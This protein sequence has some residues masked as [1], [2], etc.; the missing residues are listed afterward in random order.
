[1]PIHDRPN[2]EPSKQELWNAFRGVLS[3]SRQGSPLRRICR[4]GDLPLSFAQQ[5]FWLIEQLQPDSSAYNECVAFLRLEGPL[6][7]AALEQSLNEIRHRHEVLRTTF[8]SVNGQPIQRISPYAPVALSAIDLR[9]F[10]P[11]QREAI[12]QRHATE[13]AQQ[14]F[15]LEQGPLLRVKLLRLKQEEYIF[16]VTIHHIIYDGWSHSVFIQELSELYKAFSNHNPSPL[17]ELPI[18]YADFAQ[19]QRQWLQGKILQSQI[20]YWMQQLSGNLPVLHLPIDRPQPPIQTYQG[21]THAQ[22]LPPKLIEAL[23]S[24]SESED[25]TLFM[26]LLAAF[27]ALLYRYTGQEDILIGSPIANRNRREISGLIGCFINTLVLRTDL[28]RNPTFQE[29]LERVRAV[30]LAAFAHQDLPFEKLVE[31]LQPE[32]DLSRSPLFQVMFVFQHAPTSSLKLEGLTLSP[33]PV[34]NKTAKFNLT[35][36]LEQSPQ[37]LMALWEYNTD[38]F[39]ASTI[40]RMAGHFQILLEGIVAQPQQRIAEL[41]LL[42]AVEQQQLRVEWNDTPAD[43]PLDQCIHELFEM[44]VQRT[45]DA[46]AVVYGNQQLTYYQLNSRANQLARYLQSV[47]VK[48]DARVG[49]CVERSLEMVVGLLGIL[50]AGGAYVPLDPH[51]PQERLSDMLQ[52]AA[53]SVLLTQQQWVASLPS[54]R[55]DIVCLDSQWQVIRTQSQENPVSQV[56]ATNLAYVIYTSGSTGQPKGIA[57]QHDSLVNLIAWQLE[58]AMSN[59]KAKTLQ[60]A[61]VSFDVSFQEIFSTWCGG[62]VLV[63]ISEEIRRDACAL[64]RLLVEAEI[65]RLFLPVVALQQLA[66]VADRSPCHPKNLREIITAG[67]QLQLTP[68][69]ISFFNKLPN[70]VLHNHYG[71]SETHVVTA[72]T[73]NGSA[74]DWPAIPPIGRPIANT[75]LYILGD[76]LQPVPVGVSGELYISGAGVARGYFNRPDLTQA[77]FIP[78]PFSPQSQARLYKTGDLA[79]YLPDGNAQFLGRSDRQVKIR[80]FRIEPGEVETVLSTHPQVQQAVVVVR[81]DNPANKRLVAYLVSDQESLSSSQLR[82]FLKQKLPE[83]MIPSAF[84]MLAAMPLTPSGKLDRKALPADGEFSRE[85]NFVLPR[86]PTEAAIA[87]IFTTVLGL[88]QISIHNNFF[89]IGGHSLLA[90]QVISRLRETFN[91]ELPLRRLFELTTV[92]QLSQALL[93]SEQNKADVIVQNSQE[94]ENLRFTITPTQ[95]TS[96]QF[97]LSFTQERLWFLDRLEG[98]SN[99]YNISIAFQLQGT[100]NIAVLEQA[101]A[102]IIQRHEILRTRFITTNGTPVQIIDAETNFTLSV[103]DLQE[104]PADQRSDQIQQKVK[105][106]LETSFDLAQ[107]H[108]VRVMLLQVTPE[109]FVLLVSTHHIVFD[110]WSI[111]IF[112]QEL[113]TLYPAFLANSPASLPDLPIQYADFAVWQRQWWRGERLQTQLDY[114]KQQ[115]SHAPPLLEL[116]SDRSRPSVQTFRGNSL[117]FMLNP[118]LSNQ[119]QTLSQNAGTTLFMTLLAAFATLLYR[120]SAQE[121]ILIGSPI[122]NRNHSEIESLIGSFINTLVFRIRIQDNPGF[123]ELLTQVRQVALEAYEHQDAPFEKIVEALQPERNLSHNPLFQVMFVLQNVPEQLFKLPNLTLTPFNLD[124][125]TSKFD[126]TLSVAQTKQGLQG[127]WEYNSDLFDQDTI[128]RMNQHFQTLL[129][130]IV[131]NPQT[132]INKLP[133]LTTTERQR[134]LD[135]NNTQTEYPQDQ[136]IHQLF[137]SQV[138]KTPLAVAVVFADQQLKYFELNKK[139]NC[140]AH[141]LQKLGVGPETIVGLCVERSTDLIVSLL[142]IL[143]AGG[144]YLP[145]DPALTT[146]NLALRLP[147]G[148]VSLVISQASCVDRFE[149]MTVICLDTD[150]DTI[151]EQPDTNPIALAAPENLIYVLYTSGSTGRPKG[152]AVEHRQL[153]NYFYG[154]VKKL[155]LP[156]GASFATVSTIAADLGNTMIFP[157]LCTGG[158]L[159]IISYECATHPTALANYCQSHPIDCLKIVPSHLAALLSGVQPEKILPHQCL[160]LGGETATW[161]LIEQI[162]QY[163]ECRIL[164]HYGPTEAT[165]GVLTYPVQMRDQKSAT[166]PLG[167]SLPNCQIYLLDPYRQP[168][169][170]GVPGEIYIGGDSLARGYLNQ[171]TLTAERFIPDPLSRMPLARLYKTGDLARYLPDGNIEYLGRIDRQV[172]I[173]GFR[174]ELEEIEAVLNQHPDVLQTAVIV[175]EDLGGDQRLVAYIVPQEPAPPVSELCNFLTEKLPK[176]M[177]P[178]TFVLLEHLPLTQNGKIDRHALPVPDTAQPQASFIAPRNPL[179][180]QL[181]EIWSE[182]LN[183]QPVGI[184]D[185]FFEL[186]GHSLMAVR[187][188]V[189]LEQAFK[190]TLPIATLFQFPTLEDLA[191]HLRTNK[192]VPSPEILVPVQPK[193]NRTPLFCVHPVGGDVLCYADLAHHLGDTQPFWALRSQGIAGECN[194]L[195]QIE[196]MAAAYIRALQTIQP[197]GPYQ[198]VGWS[199]GGAIAFEM[200]VQLVASGQ[201][202]SLLAL[203]DSFAPVRQCK[204]SPEIDEAMLLADW[205]KNLGGANLAVSVRKLRLLEPQ[206]QF[207][208]V[209]EQAK[210][211]GLLPKEM[212]QKH[213][214]LLF[215]VFK[216]N[217]LSWHSYL[218]QPYPGRITLFCASGTPKEENQHP[219]QGWGELATG[220]IEMHNIASDHFSIIKTQTLAELLKTNLAH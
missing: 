215:Q 82:D 211:D 145:L 64:L 157:S 70:C 118:E 137:E 172:K 7:V 22:G 139:A 179:E 68:T 205:V 8:T 74:S 202:V 91:V 116:P 206:E 44:Q 122:A 41:P 186:G 132:Q 126:L 3:S 200:A 196:D 106:E 86:T 60:F 175:R 77:K 104:F 2:S 30:A 169:P 148:Q 136:C 162:R 1:M 143:K 165:V 98:K 31:E 26:T 96:N 213:A 61:P 29:L 209:L 171:S 204:D 159:H 18:Q 56:S 130:G 114:W 217:V 112:V 135:W 113:L 203:I 155:D 144:A 168:T 147:D 73:L 12:A 5:R 154:I 25:A 66:Q 108:S 89:E 35:L 127:C 92:A 166:V 23:Q 103:V 101:L 129:G 128:I 181:A 189:K 164:N 48:A 131:T 20:D 220:G 40:E 37:G 71:P 210:R 36:S 115:L 174:I 93:A 51:Y 24:L 111:G 170:V 84:V 90:T 146:Q 14:P 107:S 4:E 124:S 193:G 142:G 160:V 80:G 110:G 27:K 75:Q 6:N 109:A 188:M 184:K 177:I 72:F 197:Q 192:N 195:T 15:D 149:Q 156:A 191:N 140:L 55:A 180:R 33:L 141:Y 49:L 123:T 187:L 190:T 47:G 121:D 153:L 38:L 100:L 11:F 94:R 52:D 46:V 32:R 19:W 83:Y 167:R 42:T 97:P 63:L 21:A 176:H 185:N 133:L 207:N 67:E 16:L 39:D 152:V 13:A 54:H 102:A 173:R 138:E 9:E 199:M 65:E 81:E 58:N 163:A 119:L 208:S 194:P 95:R 10:P 88:Q 161:E 201:K 53:V 43:Y 69:L 99:K 183:V 105:Q 62:G 219:T 117:S 17:P 198:L 79:R 76:N 28:S 78:D 59:S 45:P 87:H 120:Y 85:D 50:K 182:I 158:C 218:P 134:L 34:E 57:M 216:A 151:L 214:S 178:A 212:G 150:W 125:V